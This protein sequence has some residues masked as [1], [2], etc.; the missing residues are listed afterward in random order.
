MPA[1]ETSPVVILGAGGHAKVVIEILRDS[2]PDLRLAG[3]LD[4][5]PR[6]RS[7]LGAEVIGDDSRLPG[8][9]REGVAK[10]FVAVGDNRRREALGRKL[11]EMGFEL[12]RAVSPRAYVSPSARLGSGV[13]VMA[14]AVV[15]AEAEVLDLVIVNTGALVDHECRLARAAHVAPGCALAGRVSVGERALLGVGVSVVPGASI[16][17]DAVVGA[18][19]CVISDI[20]AGVIAKGLP[21]RAGQALPRGD[22][23]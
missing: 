7:V 16:G 18:G 12:V 15:G 4:A 6:P 21:A 8:L 11:Q 1:P 3:L 20:P 22:L 5:D 2:R 17:A 14:G 13:A 9:R 19:S 23:A 10:A